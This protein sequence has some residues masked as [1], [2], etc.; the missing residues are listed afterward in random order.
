MKMISICILSKDDADGLVC[1]ND[2]IRKYV[3]RI[4][5]LLEHDMNLEQMLL[6]LDIIENH[7][8]Y[9][10]EILEDKDCKNIIGVENL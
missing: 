10:D 3:S 6:Y 2:S 8:G 4:R 9:M 5:E 7:T 1:A